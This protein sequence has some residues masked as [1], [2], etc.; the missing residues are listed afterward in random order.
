[1][2]NLVKSASAILKYFIF[3]Q[4][5]AVLGPGQCQLPPGLAAGAWLGRQGDG[6]RRTERGT[7]PGLQ[8]HPHSRA[9]RGPEAATQVRHI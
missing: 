2:K 7:Q 9:G 5:R 8:S 3:V 1:M 4:D 6:W